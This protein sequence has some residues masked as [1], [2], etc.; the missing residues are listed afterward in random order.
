VTE[1]DA[2]EQLIHG[3]VA[4]HAASQPLATALICGEQRISYQDLDAAASNWARELADLGVGPG[5]VI[6]VT[7]PRSARLVTAQLAILKCGA[8]YASVDTRWPGD[9]LQGIFDQIAP[10]V[11]VTD[12]DG[13]GYPVYRPP[14]AE[15]QGL[16]PDRGPAFDPVPL[17][18]SAAAMVFFT[19]GTTG[20][21][22]GVV[23]PHRAVTR[24][25][26]PGGFE[27]FGPGH[28]IPQSAPMP[29]DMYGFE[30]W[31]QL[32]TGGTVVLVDAD[33][34]MPGTLRQL[35]RTCGVDTL[36]ITASLFNLF[37]DE[38]LNCFRGL[39]RVL[40]G[41]ERLSPGHV[42]LFL[43]RHPNIPLS[44]NYGPAESCMITTTYPIG[45]A[46]CGLPGG[47][48]VGTAV[49]GT[50]VLVLDR[51]DRP[52]PAGQ[53]GEICIAGTGLAVGYLG[54]A[55]LTAAKFPTVT[56][57]GTHL[58]IYRTGDIGVL[59]GGGVLHYT[60][61]QD[62]QVKI[63][64]YRIE[65]AEVETAARGMPGVGECVAIPVT[66]PSGEVT[67]LALFYLGQAGTTGLP[68]ANSDDPLS[69][70]DQLSRLLPSYM[71][72]GVVR[73]LERFPVSANGKVDRR[74]LQDLARRPTR[75]RA[76]RATAQL[77]A[78]AVKEGGQ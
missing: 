58:R 16:H 12:S 60:G 18:G 29:W 74:V 43:E 52:C 49:P 25:F 10:T 1:T 50:Q 41:G 59:D 5:Q 3:K 71:V 19:S 44:N 54:N 45:L 55:E 8:A 65:P 30:L 17:D 15:G 78:S 75:R 64:G 2:S 20:R 13:G 77:A 61:R 24:L 39:R 23:A 56:V 63:S 14:P 42:R 6:P 76:A 37:V 40:T 21:P 9:R 26:Q 51:D 27:G 72:P 67:Q 53:P 36:W 4:R 31:G 47:I 7:L 46:D 69:V 70:R 66:A 35:V 73:R 48:P 28:A 62:R 34:L 11:V 68:S 32:T 22:K 57:D 33:H 38:D